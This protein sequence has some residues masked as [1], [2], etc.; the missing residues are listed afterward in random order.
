MTNEA[1]PLL[2]YFENN[3]GR[4]MSKWLHYFDIYHRHF[5]RFRGRPITVVEIGVYHGGSLQMWRKYFGEQARI[6]GVDVN[7]RL[8]EISEP[9]IEIIIGDQGDRRFLRELASKTGKIDILIDDG[10]HMMH[11]QIATVEEL[12]GSVADDGLILVE[13]T[14]TS[15]WR[16][17]GGGLRAQY[18]FMQFAKHL[19]DELN[20]WHSRDPNSLA[21]GVFTQTANSMHFYDSVVVIEKYKRS[22][23][24][25]RQTGT[26]SFPLETPVNEG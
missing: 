3:P 4:L 8:S 15:Y 22:R 6:I 12:Y 16:E 17:Y 7:P 11:Q 20:A 21:P 1:N 5:Q 18:S 24:H 25:E 14:H 19:V 23:P 13:D 10:G 2:E 9:G 26:P